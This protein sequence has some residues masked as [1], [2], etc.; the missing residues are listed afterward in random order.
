MI[1]YTPSTS[2][3]TRLLSFVPNSDPH[4]TTAGLLTLTVGKD[5]DSYVVTEFP[6]GHPGRGFTLSKP[7][8]NGYTVFCSQHG[9]EADSC[10]CPAATYRGKCK[11]RDAIRTLLNCGR[12]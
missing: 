6:T 3:S 11:H 10:D 9:A 8:G 7:A 4:S 12:L 1:A 5:T 2:K